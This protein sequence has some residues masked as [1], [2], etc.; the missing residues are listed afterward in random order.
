MAQLIKKVDRLPGWTV[1]LLKASHYRI[2]GPN[3]VLIFAA[4]TPSD[5][6]SV[7]NARSQLRKRGADV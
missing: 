3:G 6:R 2:T 5:P 7:R 4:S 1:R